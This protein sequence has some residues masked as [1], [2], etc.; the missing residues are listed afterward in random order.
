MHFAMKMSIKQFFSNPSKIFKVVAREHFSFLIYYLFISLIILLLGIFAYNFIRKR[1]MYQK[2]IEISSI[3]ELKVDQISDFREH[4]Y[5]DAQ[6]YYGNQSFIRITKNNMESQDSISQKELTNYLS[7]IITNHFYDRIRIIDLQTQ[8]SIFEIPPKKSTSAITTDSAFLLAIKSDSILIGDLILD[9]ADSSI[10]LSIFVPLILQSKVS[11]EKIA[12]LELMIDPYKGLYDQ[13]QSLPNKGQTGEVLVCRKD[14]KNILYLNEL[15]FKK[16]SALRFK[17][18]ITTENLPAARPFS[19]YDTVFEGIDYRGKEVLAISKFVPDTKWNVVVKFDLDEINGSI[20]AFGILIFILALIMMIATL[21]GLYILWANKRLIHFEEL[22]KLNEKLKEVNNEL[23]ISTKKAKEANLLKS[24]F[25]ANMSHEIRTPMNAIIGFAELLEE[26]ERD[27]A[28]KEFCRIIINRSNDLL[29]L[30]NDILYISKIDS[31]TVTLFQESVSFGN[32]LDE[33]YLI[34]ENKL[35][36]S[37]IT[38]ITLMCHKPKNASK[39]IITT[40]ILKFRQIFTNLLDNAFKFTTKGE[41]HFGY[42]THNESILECFVSDSGIGID[43]KDQKVIFEMFRQVSSQIQKN[44]GG[45]G[46]GLAICKGNAELLGGDIYVESS[47]GQGSKF[48]FTIQYESSVINKPSITGKKKSFN[49]QWTAKKILLV[50]DD[51]HS[52]QLMKHLLSPTGIIIYIATTGKE[53]KSYY[54]KLDEINL[55][56]MDLRLPDA[57]GVNIMKQMK[58]LRKELPVIAQTAYAMEED[59][60]NCKEA[61]FDSFISKPIKHDELLNMISFYID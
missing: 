3:S 30:I 60:Y 48:I 15:R 32:F 26:T 37:N 58:I 21:L 25:L 23:E 40:D 27:I 10:H 17:L 24:S 59:K 19:Q 16:N 11:S 49:N 47:I 20:R 57:N 5:R 50:E 44:L 4:L 34:Y 55:V 36:Q 13:I 43:P 61:G 31:N 41:I 56:F 54:D 52:A 29:T 28:S 7:P 6:L 35:Q 18:P 33:L 12:L 22:K 1:F 42:S 39:F 2:G 46:L 51:E 14:G 9:Q 53:A 8:K 45:T 38:E